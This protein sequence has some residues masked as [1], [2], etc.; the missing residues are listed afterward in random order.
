MFLSALLKEIACWYSI[1]FYL[2]TLVE[3]GTLKSP[4]EELEA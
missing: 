3:N 4:K 1:I 2:M